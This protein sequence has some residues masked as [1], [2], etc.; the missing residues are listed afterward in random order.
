MKIGYK[1]DNEGKTLSWR[2]NGSLIEKSYP[3]PVYVLALDDESS[4]LVVEPD[5]EHSPDNAIIF[6][7]D[8]SEK[9]RII[10]PCKGEGAI[11]FGD[12]YYVNGEPTLISV[13]N[14][15]PYAC[16]VNSAGD[17]VRVYETR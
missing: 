2:H 7:E 1:L 14:R 16:V 17:I 11:C 10:N 5:N 3:Y 15:V 13:T 9:S 12:A 4:I 8:G 6:N